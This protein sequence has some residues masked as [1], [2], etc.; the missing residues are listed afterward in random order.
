MQPLSDL[1]VL[2]VTVFL[3]GPFLSMTLARLGAE[4]IK[5][6]IPGRGDPV[7]GNGP[8]AGPDGIHSEQRSEQHIATR[9]LKRSQ[10]V[11]SVTLDLKNPRGRELFLEMARQSDIVL[12]NLAPG[13]MTRLGLG[14]D[15]V[16]AVNPGII[17]ASIS[18]Y[19]QTGPYSQQPAH[20]PQIQGMSG[21]MD[22]N[23]DPDGPPT[24]VGFYIGDL[25]TP[26]FAAT[27][28]LAALRER[29]RAGRGTYL[30]VSMMDTLTSLMLM[31][32]LE[33]DLAAGIPL[34][35]GNNSRSGPT[36]QYQASDGVVII[37]AASDDQW[38]RLCNAM[39]T[40]EL[41]NDPRF[42]R[43]QARS[44]NADAARAEV[45][46]RIGKM[47]RAEALERLSAGDVPC[48]PVRAVAEILADPHF[49]DRGA[50]RPM[51]NGA[52]N[53][54][55]DEVVAG[56]PVLFDGQPLPDVPGAPA[57]GQHNTETLGSLC[58]LDADDLTKLRA[59]GVI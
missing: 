33:E 22:I 18:G 51:L 57:L 12:E 45:Q 32:N 39:G 24:R 11:K 34:R 52:F 58:G 7:R 56:F 1:R 59:D 26:M 14:Y 42:E 37:T 20:D 35:T 36:G 15:D 27:A 5:V 53:G 3:A 47:T 28:I 30:D 23:G 9:F 49:R 8:F 21:L 38:R 55:V 43:Y 16:A 46:R 25:V 19:G 6:E 29:E 48:A 54:A 4:V 31:E 2:A 13:S 41:I 44:E 50:L 40:P 10:G 17:Y